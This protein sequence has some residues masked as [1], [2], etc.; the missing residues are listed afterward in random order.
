[1]MMM[2]NVMKLVEMERNYQSGINVMMGI[3]LMEMDVIVIVI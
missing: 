1:M 3:K 2:G